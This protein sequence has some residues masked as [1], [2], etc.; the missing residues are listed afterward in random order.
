MLGSWRS[1]L[2]AV[3]AVVLLAVVLPLAVF[4]LSMSIALVADLVTIRQDIAALRDS[5]F[6]L[7]YAERYN[8]RIVFQYNTGDRTGG[9][10]FASVPLIVIY[11]VRP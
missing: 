5:A 6:R 10:D 3:L 8:G 2:F 1:M 7:I 11:E 4:T 9:G